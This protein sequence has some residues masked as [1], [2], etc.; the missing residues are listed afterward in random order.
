MHV[1]KIQ[2]LVQVVGGRNIP[3]RSNNPESGT[4]KSTASIT[5]HSSRPNGAGADEM[6]ALDESKFGD[7][8]RIRTVVEIK[9]QENELSTVS[10]SGIAPLWK[11]S[12]A[13]PFRS[14]DC[15]VNEYL[16]KI[17]YSEYFFRAPQDDCTPSNLEQVRDVVTF[18]LF[19]EVVED[20]AK[21][22]GIRRVSEWKIHL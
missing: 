15:L 17:L 1:D 4:S 11:Q 18:T 8:G 14:C 2:L 16:L 7:F 13:F 3:L 6:P 5:R 9:F 21:I 22:G 20:D 12:L 19:D 10:A